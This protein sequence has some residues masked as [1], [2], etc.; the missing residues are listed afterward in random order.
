MKKC[1]VVEIILL[2][3][4]TLLLVLGI[5]TIVLLVSTSNKVK[6]QKSNE[7]KQVEKNT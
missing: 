4:S 6:E 1:N 3:L 7:I 5:I 2:V